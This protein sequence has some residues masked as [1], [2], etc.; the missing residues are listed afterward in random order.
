MLGKRKA[1][2]ELTRNESAKKSATNRAGQV[3]AKV[4]Q[5]QLNLGQKVQSKCS[6][7]GMEYV[8]SSAEDR[9]LHEKYHKQN[10]EGYDVGKTFVEKSCTRRLCKGLNEDEY[11]VAVDSADHPHRRKRAQAV[12]DIVQRELGAVAISEEELWQN[13]ANARRTSEESK[14]RSYMYIRGNKCIGFLLVERI[15]GAYQVLDPSAERRQQGT[16]NKIKASTALSALRAR[17]E[18]L[19][20]EAEECTRKP[21]NLSSTAAS[22]ALGISRI[23]VSPT[24]RGQSIALAL[25]DRA[26]GSNL[27]ADM[28]AST[29]AGILQKEQVAFSP[30][31]ASGAKL[32]RKWFGKLYGWKVYTD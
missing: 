23:W 16:E 25:L 13:N 4:F 3:G 17:R 2:Q 8:S 21:V 20:R 7:C 5:M 9:S 31:T 26:L 6:T 18:M 1:L 14:F 19:Q 29:D 30:P 15:S 27:S 24:H 10:T 12:L 22:A 28:Q 32:A 11:V